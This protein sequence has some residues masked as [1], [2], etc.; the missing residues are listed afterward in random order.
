MKDHTECPKILAAAARA[1]K[2]KGE[3]QGDRARAIALSLGRSRSLTMRALLF[4]G[5]DHYD[6]AQ[7]DRLVAAAV[8]FAEDIAKQHDEAAG[9]VRSP[10]AEWSL[11]A[12]QLPEYTFTSE[13]TEPGDDGKRPF[14]CVLEWVDD[15]FAPGARL[16]FP[17]VAGLP[18]GLEF[19]LPDDKAIVGKALSV[20]ARVDPAAVARKD[21]FKVTSL[22]INATPAEEEDEPVERTREEASASTQAAQAR[23]EAGEG[24]G[25][26]VSHVLPPR[27]EAQALAELGELGFFLCEAARNGD[28]WPL[29]VLASAN[30]ITTQE[31][32]APTQHTDGRVEA[33]R[34]QAID[35]VTS[36]RIG[37]VD[38]NEVRRQELGLKV[39]PAASAKQLTPWK[40]VRKWRTTPGD[41]TIASAFQ[42]G[43]AAC[44]RPTAVLERG[45][46]SGT[47]LDPC[48][49]YA[50]M[51]EGRLRRS[52]AAPSK[53]VTIPFW[54]KLNFA[55]LLERLA[56]DPTAFSVV[57]FDRSEWHYSPL[58]RPEDVA[59]TEVDDAA[60]VG[61]LDDAG[62]DGGGTDGGRG[63][64][65]VTGSG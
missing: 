32:N 16:R 19:T 15:A 64:R 43:V 46:T 21:L 47:L 42:F 8:K 45:T 62:R 26:I 4:A 59:P 60:D 11:V 57:L 27:D 44:V 41:E 3:T 37:G 24:R 33:A 6:K 50:M 17:T 13:A 58:V 49:V 40:A 25:P 28:C 63:G 55:D 51:E 22:Q 36:S 7:N 12:G 1:M 56:I 53:P 20:A 65:W 18:H 54:F 35:L 14:K 9:V 38:G 5:S 48:R 52:P 2:H 10:P 34:E 30:K 61:N 29:S 39:T 23:R 31:A